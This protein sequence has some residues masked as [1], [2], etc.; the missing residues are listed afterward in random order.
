M[1]SLEAAE[2]YGLRVVCAHI[3][4]FEGNATRFAMVGHDIG[5][6]SG[7]DKT[8]CMFEIPHKPGALYDVLT[9]FKRH[10]VNMTWIE[11]HPCKTMSDEYYFF[12]DVEGH[13]NDAKVKR[14]LAE[15]QRKSKHL[16][17]LGSFPRAG[18]ED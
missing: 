3:E 11:S 18:A 2:Q 13:V 17:L 12:V 14:A 7:H 6:R 1:A 8:S 16:T 5:G 4:D 9:P 10:K 15:V